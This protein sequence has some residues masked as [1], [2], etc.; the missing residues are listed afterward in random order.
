MIAN[1]SD[2]GRTGDHT[3]RLTTLTKQPIFDEVYK[4]LF[5]ELGHDPRYQA[6]NTGVANLFP[7]VVK[8]HREL[9]H[10]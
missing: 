2:R 7:L 9:F 1:G 4:E 10:P 6:A 5:V 3:S 8:T